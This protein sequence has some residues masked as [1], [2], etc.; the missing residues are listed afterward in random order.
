MKKTKKS[1]KLTL[2]RETLRSL[3]TGELTRAAGGQPTVHAPRCILT[4]ELST[5]ATCLC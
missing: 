5:C 3:E 1:M 4:N 2:S